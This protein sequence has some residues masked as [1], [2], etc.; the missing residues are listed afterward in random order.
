MQIVVVAE[1]IFSTQKSYLGLCDNAWISELVEDIENFEVKVVCNDSRD[2]W[3]AQAPLKLNQLYFC[4][5]SKGGRKEVN[6][7]LGNSTTCL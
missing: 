5:D 4:V 3:A 6:V 1:K 7:P 2:E